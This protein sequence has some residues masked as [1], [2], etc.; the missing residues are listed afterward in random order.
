MLLHKSLRQRQPQA[1]TALP[2]G[3]QRIENTVFDRVWYTRPVVDD[4]QFQCQP[5]TLF[6]KGDL[7]SDSRAKYQARFTY[8][9]LFRQSL[10]GIVRNVEHGL[11]ELFAVAAKLRDRGV[12]VAHHFEALGKLGQYQRPHTLAHLMNVD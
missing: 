7:P 3:H 11:Y 6:A 2:P 8:R 5:V 1:R 9:Y 10:T 12:I 4:M